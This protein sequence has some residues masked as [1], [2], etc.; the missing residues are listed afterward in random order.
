MKLSYEKI[1]RFHFFVVYL[2]Y[3]NKKAINYGYF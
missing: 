1:W 2:Q 3:K